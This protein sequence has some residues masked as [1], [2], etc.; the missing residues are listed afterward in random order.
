MTKNSFKQII[1]PAWI[2][3]ELQI[4]AKKRKTSIGRVISNLLNT[5][6]STL[7]PTVVGSNPPQPVAIHE[8]VNPESIDRILKIRGL[9]ERTIES[10]KSSYSMFL[11]YIGERTVNQRIVEDFILTCKSK[12]NAL[13]LMRILYP[14]YSKHMAFPSKHYKPKLL[15]TESQLKTFYDALP[16]QFKPIFTLLRESGLRIGEL[17]NCELDKNNKMLIPHVHGGQT[18]HSWVSF[19]KTDIEKIPE[20]HQDTVSH[21]FLKTSKTTGIK[22]YPHLLRSVFARDMSKAG[23]QDRFIDAFCGRT[24][25]NVLAKSYSDF[26]PE[27]LKEIYEKANQ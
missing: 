23:V 26:S 11:K 5:R 3:E 21:A 25:Q 27:A 6:E 22:I 8:N 13:S 17:L 12:R 19:Y 14:E 7:N 9:S 1:V 4:L 18:K 16:D 2:H 15:P 20:V 24:P 10:Y